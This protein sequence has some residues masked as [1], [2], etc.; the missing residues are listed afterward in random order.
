M[1]CWCAPLRYIFALLPAPFNVYVVYN[2]IRFII[3]Q[4]L[5]E[6]TFAGDKWHPSKLFRPLLWGLE[7]VKVTPLAVLVCTELCLAED[8]GWH[9]V[10]VGG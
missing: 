6:F 8:I 7:R 2:A 10:H 1:H 9:E 4:Q 5:N 3:V